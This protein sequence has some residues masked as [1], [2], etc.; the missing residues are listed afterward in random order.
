[1]ASPI[2]SR[3]I[4]VWRFVSYTICTEYE[5]IA[6]RACDMAP[7]SISDVDAGRPKTRHPRRRFNDR[8][9]K[10]PDRRPVSTRN[11]RT[12]RPANLDFGRTA[13]ITDVYTTHTSGN[14][15]CRPSN[16]TVGD[17]Y[18]NVIAVSGDSAYRT[19]FAWRN[20]P[21]VCE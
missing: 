9:A 7:I 15:M 18:G 8:G 5:D 20:R 16:D 14:T 10:K 4:T 12:V 6:A 11:Q 21:F 13:F 1:M 17:H 3:Q 19:K 2:V